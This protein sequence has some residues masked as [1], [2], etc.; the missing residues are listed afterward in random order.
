MLDKSQFKKALTSLH[1]TQTQWLEKAQ[2]IAI[3]CIYQVCAHENTNPVRDL[4]GVLLKPDG[5]FPKG[6][7]HAGE[8][9]FKYVSA[10]AKR[11]LQYI[12]DF[13]PC[14]VEPQKGKVK[15]QA[16][17]KDKVQWRGK[18]DAYPTWYDWTKEPT[19][20]KL[21]P[22]DGIAVIKSTIAGLLK[23]VEAHKLVISDDSKAAFNSIIETIN[24]TISVMVEAELH[25]S[26]PNVTVEKTAKAQKQGKTVIV[27]E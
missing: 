6:D 22:V 17:R 5:K 14:V 11:I 8:D 12:I 16:G 21:E 26:P 19:P 2:A 3:Y 13:S 24:K 1:T 7:A 9:R 25:D 27:A 23:R 4:L 18:E 10:D 20:P 15:F